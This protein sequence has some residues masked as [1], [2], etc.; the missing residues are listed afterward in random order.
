V[1][2]ELKD[3]TLWY[4]G[5]IEVDPSQLEEMLLRGVPLERIAVSHLTPEIEE[6]NSNA[7]TPLKVKSANS[8]LSFDW[9]LPDEY[10]Y[11]DVDGY[12]LSLADLVEKD[13][14]YEQRISRLVVE[15]ELFKK[16][17]LDN[18]IRV[19]AY[20]ISIFQ[21]EGVVWGVGRGS[22]CSS[23]ILFL[24]GLHEVDPVKF[25]IDIEDF[26]RGDGLEAEGT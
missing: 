5:S 1:K 19:L 25:G 12:L 7:A 21:R 13:K 16:L 4:D 9:M 14:L 3:Y 22:S 24:M 20:V 2:T 8:M 10:K 11:L 26:L 15:I 6:L 23:Y 17:N 18:V